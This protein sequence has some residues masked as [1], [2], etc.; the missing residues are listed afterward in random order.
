ME[1]NEEKKVVGRRR[2]MKEKRLKRGR[3]DELGSDKVG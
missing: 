2:K 3:V 1:R